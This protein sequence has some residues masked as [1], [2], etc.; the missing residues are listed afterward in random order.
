MRVRRMV[1]PRLGAAA[2]AMLMVL[3]ATGFLPGS[4]PPANGADG[5]LVLR[6]RVVLATGVDHLRYSTLHPLNA[7]HVARVKAGSNVTLRPVLSNDRV[8][9][10]SSRP[11]LEITSSMCRR[12]GA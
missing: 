9:G 4:A 7:I 10:D 6:G 1:P 5:R 12:V 11:G 8:I 2:A 3:G